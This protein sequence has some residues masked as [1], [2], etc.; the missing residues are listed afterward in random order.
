MWPSHSRDL[1]IVLRRFDWVRTGVSAAKAH[2]VR[3]SLPSNQHLESAL[4][5]TQDK[6]SGCLRRAWFLYRLTYE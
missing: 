2:K 1:S 6:H 4:T 3:R 5:Y